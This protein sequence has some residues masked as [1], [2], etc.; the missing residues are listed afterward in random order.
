MSLLYYIS[1]HG[2]GHA[3]RCA[4]TAR[5]LNQRHPEI[6]V[7]IRTMANARMFAN[8]GPHVHYAPVAIDRGA[9]EIDAMRIDWPATLAQVR[10]LI[11]TKDAL[12]AAE[13]R[14]IQQNGIRLIIADVPFLAGY[15]AQAAGVPC[16]AQCNFMWDW[17]YQ[18]H[19][20]DQALLDAIRQGYRL[21]TGQLRLP[22]PHPCDHFK[23]VLDVPLICA[24]S[25]IS[26]SQARKILGIAA[27]EQ[28]PII[29]AAMRG[30]TS[31]AL[32]ARLATLSPNYLLLT[33]LDLA[34]HP[35]LSFWD[36]LQVCDVVVSKPGHGI[37]TD[38]CSL[39]VALLHPPRNGFRED[40]LI[41]S[42]SAEHMRQRPIPLSDY[43]QGNWKP[44]LDALLAQPRLAPAT[45]TNGREWV[46]DFIASQWISA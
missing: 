38:C 29:F 23:K 8:L 46:A 41:L 28:R 26:K 37:V 15:I 12:I 22:Y 30:G 10:E 27:S 34:R 1:G 31:P 40:E 45:N 7:Y 20:D 11:A 33:E 3:G 24:P 42:A 25:N 35:Q 43:S 13:T 9:I 32:H 18:P 44:H 2:F 5:L 6:P 4:Q 17:I 19:T 14:F 21:M 36:I 39:G 16:Y